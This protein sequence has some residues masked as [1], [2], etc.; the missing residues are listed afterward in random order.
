MNR[1]LFILTFILA[2]LVIGGCGI[3]INVDIEQGSGNV[4]TANRD[5]SG[6]DKLS[7]SGIGDVTLVQG[8]K[9]ALKIEAEDNVI[10]HITTEVRDGTLFIGFDKKAVIPTKPIKYT[11]T[12]R[13]IRRLDTQGVSN[14]N[15]DGLKTDN[16][17]ISISGTGNIDIRKLTANNIA[18]NVSGAGSFTALGKVNS[19][20][21]SLSGA[22]NYD[23]QELQSKTADVT[24]SGLGRV[25]LW[26]TDNLDVTISGTGGVDYYGSP[27]ITQQISGLGKIT[28]KG[29][30]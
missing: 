21:V 20:K 10:K 3:N 16:L 29:D 4:T 25:T 5:V 30:K 8:D 9:E 2:A 6:F 23:G 11:L 15:A 27:Q 18:I 26:T 19:Q 13:N 1:S 14:L 22:G 12:M 17:E 7:I 24:I 28:H